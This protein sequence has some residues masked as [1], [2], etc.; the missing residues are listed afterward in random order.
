MR[1]SVDRDRCVGAG[2]CV[3]SA[4]LVFDQ[5]EDDG[6]V[7]LQNSDPPLAELDAVGDAV[8]RCPAGAITLREK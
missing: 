3:F 8:D 4:E 2:Q 6:L 5:D 7:V 1:V